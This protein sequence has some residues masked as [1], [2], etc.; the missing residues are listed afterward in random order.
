MIA[1]YS[2]EAG[3]RED[4]RYIVFN[5]DST[6]LMGE[7]ALVASANETVRIYFG[8]AGPNKIASFHI[9]GMVMDRVY[10]E[11]D[12][13]SPP[14]HEVQTTLVPPGG[15]AVVDVT[16]VVPGAY[17]LLDHAIF[18]TEKGAAG[19]LKVTG[20]LRPDIYGGSAQTYDP[21]HVMKH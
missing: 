11:G 9:V 16:A 1:A 12:L 13:V 4:P 14:A 3:L 21:E 19:T 18:R 8:N 20:T 5:G 2:H 17:T 15:A 6:S 10:R 7:R